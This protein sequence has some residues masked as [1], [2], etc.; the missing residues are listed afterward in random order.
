MGFF[1]KRGLLSPFNYKKTT[2]MH[3]NY[4]VVL[5]MKKKYFFKLS[6]GIKNIILN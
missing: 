3:N 6:N 5:G 2:H 1:H 4:G